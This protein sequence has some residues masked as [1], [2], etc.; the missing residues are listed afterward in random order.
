MGKSIGKKIRA[1][2]RAHPNP[3]QLYTAFQ[4]IVSFKQSQGDKRPVSTILAEAIKDYNKKQTN[5]ARV[6]SDEKDAVLMLATQVPEFRKTLLNHWLNFPCVHSAVPVLF[7]AKG[8][9]SETY[10]PSIKKK[11][12]PRH[13]MMA[14]NSMEKNLLWLNRCIGKFMDKFKEEKEKGATVNIS[15]MASVF[16]RGNEEEVLYHAVGI[17]HAFQDEFKKNV[18]A[19]AWKEIEG[20][21]L[22]G[23]LDRE[24]FEKA[25]A[26][27][28]T[29]EV[30]DFRFVQGA[31]GYDPMAVDAATQQTTAMDAARDKKFDSAFHLDELMLKSETDRWDEHVRKLRG[32][33][34]SDQNALTTHREAVE[35]AWAKATSDHIEAMWPVHVL[36][37]WTDLAQS[38]NTCVNAFAD[39][40]EVLQGDVF[41]V[42]VFNLAYMGPEHTKLLEDSK[43]TICAAIA[44]DDAKTCAIVIAPTVA[45]F[46]ETYIKEAVTKCTESLFDCLRDGKL[47]VKELTIFWNP[48]TQ[49]STTRSNSHKAY[50][51]ISKKVKD[52]K[53]VSLFQYS[54]LW[55]R[56]GCDDWVSVQPRAD[57]VDPTW[58][59]SMAERG[60]LGE[61]QQHKQYVTG[62][63][64]YSE[65][66]KAL[67]NGM[68][69]NPKSV[70]AWLEGIGYDATLSMSVLARS[71]VPAVHTP[72]EMVASF[73][74]NGDAGDKKAKEGYMTKTIRNNIKIKCKKKEYTIEGAPDISESSSSVPVSQ[75]PTYD[76]RLFTL[77]KPMADKS[78]PLRKTFVDKWSGNDVPMRFK[79]CFKALVAKHDDKY[80]KAGIAWAGETSKRKAADEAKGE[81][82][83][84]IVPEE[85]GP[86]SVSDIEAKHGSVKTKALDKNPKSQ[87][88][89]AADGAIFLQTGDEAELFLAEHALHTYAGEFF[90]GKQYEKGLKD[91]GYH[92]NI[93]P[94]CT[95]PL[96][97]SVG[98]PKFLPQIP[99][100]QH[101]SVDPHWATESCTG[102][103]MFKWDI[104]NDECVASCKCEPELKSEL[105]AKDDRMSVQ[106]F[107]RYLEKNGKVNVE[108]ECH[109]C[110]RIKPKSNE[111]LSTYEI[112]N[113]EACG[114]K[115]RE[116]QGPK[117]LLGTT[118]PTTMANCKHVAFM[119]HL[120]FVDEHST[121]E[122]G[123]PKLMLLKS[124]RVAANTIIQL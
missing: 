47:K 10:E 85:G 121:V 118:T 109:S 100:H 113:T 69:L 105:V 71:C 60:N 111:E 96:Y 57:C 81:G 41:R 45:G 35:D 7:L 2:Q 94:L 52:N 116:G 103:Q 3:I 89:V 42:L 1:A 92:E 26:K 91:G 48:R 11:D 67:W 80:N 51:C 5:K 93:S 107:L 44:L 84:T 122:P 46:K 53:L 79:D 98:S 64:L 68:G 38:M 62:L 39:Y 20:K 21:F 90:T 120:K 32:I 73:I 6:S 114:Y 87:L 55:V 22:R 61:A 70:A 119:M 24:L 58:R 83:K 8:W 12:Y 30:M 101:S 43:S 27:D 123:R 9:L 16:R 59:L 95:T 82:A 37:S 23:G 25:R 76:E 49:W 33:Y 115:P 36:K 106:E 117:T 124:I 63:S 13:Y 31:Q 14:K 75:P 72:R 28:E 104:E 56:E 86:K 78:L 19:A 77:T 108:I 74:W 112:S 54:S 29:V 66:G 17:F 15:N 65:L 102:V 34:A 110:K 4:R 40:V 99:P 88:H 18:S 50:M 97:S